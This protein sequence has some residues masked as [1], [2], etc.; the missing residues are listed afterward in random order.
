MRIIL[1]ILREGAGLLVLL[2][3]HFP[4]FDGIEKVELMEDFV[5]EG[6]SVEWNLAIA[7]LGK[8][9]RD[10][11]PKVKRRILVELVEEEDSCEYF[12]LDIEGFLGG[13]LVEELQNLADLLHL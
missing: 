6:F 10:V 7:F 8:G 5:H 4:S 12:M 2:Q 13:G 9:G 11:V 3:K 1:V